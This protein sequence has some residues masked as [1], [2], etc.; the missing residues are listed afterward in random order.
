[1]ERNSVHKK[2][3]H[4]NWC[5]LRGKC[6]I[7]LYLAILSEVVHSLA[8]L[9]ESTLC[10]FDSFVVAKLFHGQLFQQQFAVVVSTLL[11]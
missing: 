8:V 5:Q 6:L 7:S 10:S 11:D 4:G 3:Q 2:H 1:M 9:F